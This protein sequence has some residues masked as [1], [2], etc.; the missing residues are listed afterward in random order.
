MIYAVLVVAGGVLLHAAF[1]MPHEPVATDIAHFERYRTSLQWGAFVELASALPLGV[2]VA[3]VV[4]RLQFLGVRAAGAQIALCGG[5]VAT[6]MLMLSALAVWALSS[7]GVTEAA[8]AVRAFQML[9]FGTGGPGFVSSF[10][11][12]VAGVSVASGL[13][14][15]IP[16]WLMWLGIFV[17]V[18]SELTT[19][20]LVVRNAAYFIPV[21]RF[22]G[23][24]WM[25]GV[26]AT[27]P[28]SIAANISSDR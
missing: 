23:V 5:I 27:L 7:P 13:H 25:I 24:I 22:I 3:A 28:T 16:R 14:R 26:A 11:L 12:F 1:S 15:F 21:G 9:S 20:M 4:G 18:A 19:L 10:G 8:G 17:A 6:T 2:F